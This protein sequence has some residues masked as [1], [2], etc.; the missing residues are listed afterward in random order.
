MQ[1]SKGTITRAQRLIRKGEW[2][3]RNAAVIEMAIEA[4]DQAHD[5]LIDRHDGILRDE[6][7]I[8]MAIHNLMTPLK[9]L[10][11][12]QCELGHG[13]PWEVD[14]DQTVTLFHP[15][16]CKD[17]RY[18]VIIG[19]DDVEDNP[20]T[21]RWSELTAIEKSA[22]NALVNHFASHQSPVRAE[23]LKRVNDARDYHGN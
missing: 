2:L 15:Y 9:A 4:I 6:D 14:N 5:Q 8:E 10:Q 19:P 17:H 22:I 12:L 23:L 11:P 3:E 18:E 16:A 21:T 7:V 13:T 20:I 1:L